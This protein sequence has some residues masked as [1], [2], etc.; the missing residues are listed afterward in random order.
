MQRV[1]AVTRYVAS[2][3]VG[4]ALPV[5]R[6]FDPELAPAFVENHRLVEGETLGGVASLYRV[7]VASLFWAKWS[8]RQ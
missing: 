1:I 2:N 7:S 8:P 3:D 4:G 6:V 5:L